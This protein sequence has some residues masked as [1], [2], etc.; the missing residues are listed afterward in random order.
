MLEVSSSTLETHK[1]QWSPLHEK[2]H[3]YL[4]INNSLLPKRSTL[5]VAISGGQDSMALIKLLNDLKRIYKWNLHL[6]HG[7]HRWRLES[8][9]ITCELSRWASQELLPFYTDSAQPPPNSEAKARQWRYESLK[10]L[11]EKLNCHKIVT[12]HTG[13][14]RA[15]TLLLNIARGSN[16]HGIASLPHIRYLVN[17]NN[18]SLVRPLLNF[19]RLDTAAIC[20]KWK[21]PI[22][23]DP[24]NE[25]LYFSRNRIRHQIL[26]VLEQLHP[27][28]SLRISSLASKFQ[29]ENQILGELV[30]LTA[31]KLQGETGKH[32]L[33]RSSLILLST[34]NQRYVI[35]HWILKQ[36]HQNLESSMLELLIQ[37]LP[38]LCGPG[39][40]NLMD[41]WMLKWDRK[42][43]S[44][45]NKKSVS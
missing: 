38:L 15:E 21:L 13:S 7:N 41:G 26:P 18:L 19:S 4:L 16:R 43:L 28:A 1:K 31:N 10:Q 42:Y 25:S 32:Q 36:C 30:S 29:Q 5:L 11:A 37:R 23:Y 14:D 8:D 40:L 33:L 12:A 22:W 2:L 6:W 35:H 39:E 27:G 20:Q 44:L 3:R 24:S 17:S 34:T 45:I 9:K